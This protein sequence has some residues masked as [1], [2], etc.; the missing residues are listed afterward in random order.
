MGKSQGVCT[1]KLVSWGQPQTPAD[2]S[3]GDAA[4][5]EPSVTEMNL[6]A[7]S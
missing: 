1:A 2:F 7:R 4:V 3:D 5:K 6:K